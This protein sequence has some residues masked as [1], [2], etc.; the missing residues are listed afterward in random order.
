MNNF[1]YERLHNNLQYMKL[2]TVEELL[3]NCLELAARDSKT[4]MEVLDYLFEQERKN[5]E[6]AAIER[7]MK[8]A[9]FPVKKT[10]EEFDFEFQ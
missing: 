1:S 8:I 2:H 7:R 4:T 5:R 3:D 9:V 6:A 10:L